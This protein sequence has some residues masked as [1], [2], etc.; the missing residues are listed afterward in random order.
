MKLASLLLLLLP[1]GLF[2]QSA[3][4]SGI[5]V[6]P[7]GLPLP[8]ATAVLLQASDSLLLQFTLSDTDG[9]FAFGRVS[10]GDYLVQVSY[11][12]F[13][14]LSTPVT[15]TEGVPMV[16]VGALQLVS[17]AEQLGAAEVVGT[18]IP[19][20]FKE[21]TVEYNADSF[22]TDAGDNVEKLLKQLPGVEVGKD[23]SIKAQGETVDK[24]LVDGKEF[25]GGDAKIATNN[26][27]A[28]AIDKV[29]VFDKQSD[30]SEFTG[31]DDGERSKTINLTLKDDKKKG[32]FGEVMAGAGPPDLIDSK[33]SINRFNDKMQLAGL[34]MYNTVNKQ[35]FGFGD[36]I[37]FA[38]GM[39]NVFGNGGFSF[40]PN[41]LPIPV[42]F[43]DGTGLSTNA[44]GGL[45]FSMDFSDRLRLESSAFYNSTD[46]MLEENSTGQAT[47]G[48]AD[49]LFGDDL[50]Q[51]GINENWRSNV[52][53]KWTPD[54]LNQLILTASGRLN[55]YAETALGSNF[56][57]ALDSTLISS[58]AYTNTQGTDV[59]SGKLAAL[60]TRNFKVDGRSV[61][62]KTNGARNQTDGRDRIFNESSDF[63]V[64]PSLFSTLS[65]RQ[66]RTQLQQEAGGSLRFTEPAGDNGYLTLTYGYTWRSE[67]WDKQFFDI[68]DDAEELNNALSLGYAYTYQAHK[69]ALGYRHKQNGWNI[70]GEAGWQRSSL[71]GS[72]STSEDGIS[73]D[74]DFPVGQASLH[75]KFAGSKHWRMNYSATVREPGLVELQPTTNNSNPLN[76]YTGNPNLRPEYRHA[77]RT[78]YYSYTRF[79]GISIN[80]GGSYGYISDPIVQ[81]I[82]YNPDLSRST[83]PTNASFRTNAQAYGSIEVPLQ[84]ANFSTELELRGGLQERFVFFGETA[85]RVLQQDFAPG[86]S[87]GA[88]KAEV[89]DW[90]VGYEMDWGRA[91]YPDGG[92]AE[93]RY[94]NHNI[95][96]EVEAE[97]GDKWEVEVWADYFLWDGAAFDT[98]QQLLLY[99]GVDK[100]F[101]EEQRFWLSLEVH[102]MLNQNSGVEQFN[103]LNFVQQTRT[104]QLGRYVMLRATWKLSALG[105]GG[106]GGMEVTVD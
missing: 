85:E 20:V 82:V 88:W 64:D 97:I 22:K 45:N 95:W 32:M 67:D 16:H 39:G 35:G 13:S 98:P 44:A 12:G 92:S 100:F 34:G 1:T 74:F 70:F 76:T 26:L 43:G 37:G 102:D 33:I 14:T 21:D 71:G 54:S 73:R 91:T 58:G 6:D 41:D 62:L 105:G 40:N 28:D 96:A 2:A 65:Q 86:I 5:T 52:K 17:N 69:T 79:S 61:T 94:L 11:M 18:A 9:N 63:T 19:I 87:V 72:L 78:N 10:T 50:T 57:Y 53:L 99:A 27:P 101:G 56:N 81:S 8:S 7:D 103:D 31:V 93:Q 66:L 24:I 30:E 89:F 42:D 25:F 104:N 84:K 46:R 106:G 83:T 90:G 15:V 68:V 38:G 60:Y 48:A 51:N 80:A 49:Y 77:L 47:S 4:I 29:Q 36:L 75:K 3:T 23:G 55:D 59:L